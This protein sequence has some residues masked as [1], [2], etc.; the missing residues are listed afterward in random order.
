MGSRRRA[1]PG[2]SRRVTLALAVMAAARAF[3]FSARLP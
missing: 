2:A 1:D 3:V